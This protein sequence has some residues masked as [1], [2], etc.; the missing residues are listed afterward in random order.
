M[1]LPGNV[2][3][4]EYDPDQQRLTAAFDSLRKM[5][6]YRVP[7][8]VAAM[9]MDATSMETMFSEHVFGK[10]EWSE[11]GTQPAHELVDVRTD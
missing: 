11:V 3:F 8:D 7:A 1:N 5:I 4:L 6:F 10:Y 2:V 9:L